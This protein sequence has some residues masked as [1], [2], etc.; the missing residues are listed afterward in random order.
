MLRWSNLRD[1]MRLLRRSPS[2][3]ATVIL[4]LG[5]GIGVNTLVFTVTDA[6]LLR[7]LP[8]P[9]PNQLVWISQ[10]TSPTEAD[11]ALAPDFTVWR[12]QVQS[13]SHMAA[14]SERFRNLSGRD[15]PE[16]ILTPAV[17]AEFLSLLETPPIAGRDFLASDDQP[18]GE[19]VVILSHGFCKRYFG[20]V[21]HCVGATIR[22]NDQSVEVVG[23]LPDNF[24]FPEPAEIE[25]LTPLALGPDQASRESSMSV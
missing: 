5:L 15:Y 13:L 23:V 10:G 18:G 1:G 16:Q 21:S 7:P 2:F 22:L 24:R 14:F 19:Q 20:E 17:S 8:Y 4:V 11:Y 12:S 25:V 3:A 9:N 6:V